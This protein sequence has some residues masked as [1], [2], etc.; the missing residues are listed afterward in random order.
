MKARSEEE[1]RLR[2]E[3]E[4]ETVRTELRQLRGRVE[5]GLNATSDETLTRQWV[6]EAQLRAEQLDKELRL[7][8]Q[9]QRKERNRTQHVR[10]T[11]K[12][13]RDDARPHVYGPGDLV[14][15]KS[16]GSEGDVLS[17]PD[18]GGQLEVQVGAFKMRV[19]TTG[20]T[21]RKPAVQVARDNAAQ[22][23]MVRYMPSLPKEAPPL[24]Y[25]FRGWRAEAAIEELDR[26]LDEASVAG[27]PFL[28]IIHGK[29]TGALRKAVREYLSKHPIVK[30][31]ETA[32]QEQG[33]EGVTIVRL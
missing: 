5:A 12:V 28:R 6:T 17:S 2:V 1:A 33:G 29:G 23:S 32:P 3:Q 21:L 4:L 9:E 25:D 30:E 18:T 13:Q 27:M 16:L 15:V 31:L 11:Q 19:P 22:P 24:E 8:S 20:V 14:F 10:Q 26:R 7:K